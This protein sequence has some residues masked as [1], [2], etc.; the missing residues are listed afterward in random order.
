MAVV[1]VI[2]S[3]QLHVE[4]KL[5]AAFNLSLSSA[6]LFLRVPSVPPT[7]KE[8]ALVHEVLSVFAIV[9]GSF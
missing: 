3:L 9:H 6:A 7:S 1:F 5:K 2:V 4:P 8:Y